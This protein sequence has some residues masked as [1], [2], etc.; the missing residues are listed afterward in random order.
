MNLFEIT[1]LIV[2]ALLLIGIVYAWRK[3]KDLFELNKFFSPILSS[4]YLT[5]KAVGK[6]LPSHN[7]LTLITTVLEAAIQATRLA[8][9]MWLDGNIDK[10]QRNIYAKNYISEILE[11]AGIAVTEE[12]EDIIDGAIALTCALLPHEVNESEY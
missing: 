8:E 4:L 11:Q 10:E 7:I 9:Q 12:V 3:N 6:V 2:G 1:L 5:I